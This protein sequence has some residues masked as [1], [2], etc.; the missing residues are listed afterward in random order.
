MEESILNTTKQSLGIT[1]DNKDFDL[2][3]I[4]AINSAFMI[5]NQLGVGPKEGFKITDDSEEWGDFVDEDADL[6]AVK[7]YIH[8]KTKL[9]FDPPLNGTLIDSIDRIVRE[10]EWRLNVKVEEDNKDVGV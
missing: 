4:V 2:N 9:I 8:L 3:I 10:L 5:L 6:E 7:T 1:A